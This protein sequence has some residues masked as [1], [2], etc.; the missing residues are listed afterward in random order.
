MPPLA[1]WQ[2]PPMHTP[3]SRALRSLVTATACALA[4]TCARTP[5]VPNSGPAS[6]RTLTSLIELRL[7]SDQR[8]CAFQIAVVTTNGVV[9]L[10]G[11]VANNIDRQHA[12]DL[13]TA[14][15]ARRVESRLILSAG[16]GDRGRC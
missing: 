13:A 6:D 4:I 16:S 15:G 14:A 5:P 10:E 11:L 12:V 1:A 3:R 2:T 9:R 7:S 8:L